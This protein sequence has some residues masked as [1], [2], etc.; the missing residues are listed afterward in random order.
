MSC[1]WRI[2]CSGALI[3][4]LDGVCLCVQAAI[5]STA[6]DMA[7]SVGDEQLER[8]GMD[9]LT[10]AVLAILVTAPIGALAIGLAG[11]RLLQ[12][13]TEIKETLPE[14]KA[15]SASTPD[16]GVTPALESKL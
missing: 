5:G 16:P 1:L 15:E 10:V 3:R 6:L 14:E 13:Y 2:S 12:Q 4:V 9:V 8:Y 11:P 7:R